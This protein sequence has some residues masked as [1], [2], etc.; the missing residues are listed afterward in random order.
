MISRKL[1]KARKYLLNSVEIFKGVLFGSRNIFLRVNEVQCMC[2]S[3]PNNAIMISIIICKRAFR[4]VC[5]QT[6]G[7]GKITLRI[8]ANPF[9]FIVRGE[10]GGFV[11]KLILIK[12]N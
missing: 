9:L 2:N 7:T 11:T 4:V 6:G 1:T 3:S 10:F 8:C 5:T 12:M